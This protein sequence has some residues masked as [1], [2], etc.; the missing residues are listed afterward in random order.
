M[1]RLDNHNIRQTAGS[2]S[3]VSQLGNL[4]RRENRVKQLAGKVGKAVPQDAIEQAGA[5]TKKSVSPSRERPVTKG[6]VED[7]K[8]PK[9]H[10]NHR[11]DRGSNE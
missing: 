4:V 7:D 2:G 1:V 6:R 11:T 3:A 10:P 5:M 9:F 8:T